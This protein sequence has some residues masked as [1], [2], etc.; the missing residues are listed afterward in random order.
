MNASWPSSDAVDVSLSQAAE[1][2]D[3]AIHGFRLRKKAMMT[4][5]YTV[6][7]IKYL[8]NNVAF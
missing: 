1:Y 7:T 2:L 5:K 8:K 4:N 6:S 3:E